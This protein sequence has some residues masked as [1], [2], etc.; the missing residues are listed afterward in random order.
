M[1]LMITSQKIDFNTA[2]ENGHF[3]ELFSL[4]AN[5]YVS[6]SKESADIFESCKDAHLQVIKIA[7]AK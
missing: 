5:S 1:N 6:L 7:K 3:G 2:V 4:Q